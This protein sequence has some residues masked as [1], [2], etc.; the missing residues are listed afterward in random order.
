[1]SIQEA[2]RLLLWAALLPSGRYSVVAPRLES[3]SEVAERLYPLRDH[4]RIP[5]RRGDRLEEPE[6]AVQESAILVSPRWGSR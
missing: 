5:P 2:V 6:M 4:V 3:M 1:M